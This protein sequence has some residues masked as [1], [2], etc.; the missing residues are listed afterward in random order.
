MAKT[1]NGN[2]GDASQTAPV[3]K[4]TKKRTPVKKTTKKTAKKKA[5]A[6]KAA[7]KTVTPRAGG[8]S[9]R[10]VKILEALKGTDSAKKQ[11]TR[12]QIKKATGL[13]SGLY[14]LMGAPTK[15][16]FGTANDTALEPAGLIK[17]IKGEGKT[18]GGGP[19]AVPGQKGLRYYIT[20]KGKK[21]LQEAKKK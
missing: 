13:Q 12:A 10:Q 11:L 20:A 15:K 2:G 16:G 21:A 17:S 18:G 1:S 19:N 6:K 8:L 5:T 3:K 4:T 9:K 7:K 14:K